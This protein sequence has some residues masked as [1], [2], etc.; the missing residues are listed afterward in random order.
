MTTLRFN[1]LGEA[2]KDESL[3]KSQLENLHT[4]LCNVKA[5]LH[6]ELAKLKKEK[7]M[8]LAKREA[9]QSIA[10]R[11]A[12]WS[13]TPSGQRKFDVEADISSAKLWIESLKVRLYSIY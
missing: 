1:E 8:F 3:T 7:A 13:A 10:S 11:D 12:D 5:L 9:G 2:V 4:E 6:Q